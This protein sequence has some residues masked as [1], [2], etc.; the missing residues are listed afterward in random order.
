MFTDLSVR[1]QIQSAQERTQRAR[2][3]AQ[4]MLH[5]VSIRR[6]AIVERISSLETE[7]R[8]LLH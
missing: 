5:Q 2:A 1:S 6:G 8:Q 4:R 3:D 7:R